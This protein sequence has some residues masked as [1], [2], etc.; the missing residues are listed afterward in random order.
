[1]KTAL[2]ILV[3]HYGCSD[4]EDLRKCFIDD[5][6]S[7][8]MI[9]EAME[10]YATQSHWISCEERLPE[11][12]QCVLI[13]SEDGGVAEGCYVA[14]ENHYDQFRWSCTYHQNDVSHWQPLPQPPKQ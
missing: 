14:S 3:E 4:A 2:E 6:L 13:Y 8:T 10:S 5:V 11:S 7:E 9:L 12:G 1:M